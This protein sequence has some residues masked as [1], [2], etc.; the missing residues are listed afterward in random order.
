MSIK[1][2]LDILKKYFLYIILKIILICWHICNK[3][4]DINK[5]KMK[6][7]D[8]KNMYWQQYWLC[9]RYTFPLY[10]SLISDLMS[11]LAEYHQKYRTLNVTTYY[12][13]RRFYNPTWKS[14]ELTVSWWSIL[15]ERVFK[16]LGI[17]IY[18]SARMWC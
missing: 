3:L 7:S 18:M 2:I 9:E 8:I 15:K 11:S 12:Y 17:V 5:K 10:P 14:I 4:S 1:K 13:A 6:I 16:S